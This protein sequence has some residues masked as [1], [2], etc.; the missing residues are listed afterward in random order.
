[1]VRRNLVAEVMAEKC[2][3]GGLIATRGEVYDDLCRAWRSRGHD[4]DKIFLLIDELVWKCP[5]ATEWDLQV[6]GTLKAVRDR[7]AKREEEG[8]SCPETTPQN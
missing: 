8:G 2:V 5:E 4:P 7:E 3:Y 6:R 1:M